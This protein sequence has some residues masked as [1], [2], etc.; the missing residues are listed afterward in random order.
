MA[1]RDQ[2]AATRWVN[3]HRRTREY[4]LVHNGPQLAEG[5]LGRR[6]Q[7]DHEVLVLVDRHGGVG[8]AAVVRQIVEVGGHVRAIQVRLVVA[9][10]DA[11][12]L[13]RVGL[14]L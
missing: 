14:R 11:L 8:A 10:R 3:A 13:R 1:S 4:G 7:P 12:V 2:N 6:L 9:P 5:R